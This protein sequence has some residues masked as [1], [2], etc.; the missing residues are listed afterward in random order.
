FRILVVEDHSD[1]RLL[2]RSLLQPF[3][4]RIREATNGEDG[5]E[6]VREWNPHLVLMDRR[7]PVMDGLEATRAIRSLS[8]REQPVI[9]VITAHAFK[10]EREEALDAGCDDFLAKPFIESEFFQLL[11]KHLGVAPEWEHEQ[12][13]SRPT[14]SVPDSACLSRLPQPL[15]RRMR[16]ALV[17]ADMS[18]IAK[19]SNQIGEIDPS[20]ERAIAFFTD[21]LQYEQLANAIDSVLA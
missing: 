4:F 15:L 20:C 10:E 11:E 19:V 9:V 17:T 13:L 8:L 6:A 14:G 16:D 5:I 1:N 3:G 7:M 2:V 18:E 21:G 12:E